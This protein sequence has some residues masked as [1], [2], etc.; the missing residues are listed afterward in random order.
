METGPVKLGQDEALALQIGRRL[1]AAR[2]ARR[3]RMTLAELGGGEIT[4]AMVSKIEHG[5][6]L[7]SLP[8]LLYLARRLGMPPGDLL[9]AD[10]VHDAIEQVLVARALLAAGQH[11]QA[12]HAAQQAAAS[13]QQTG[14]AAAHGYALAVLAA[15]LRATGRLDKAEQAL[16]HAT[17]L[18]ATRQ[19]AEL[20][21]ALLVE[22]ALLELEKGA[23][24][25]AQEHLQEA[26]RMA[27]A[28][29]VWPAGAAQALLLLGREA[30]RHRHLETARLLYRQAQALLQE[31]AR[32][33]ARAA[34]RLHRL[35]RA[36]GQSA[37][38]LSLDACRAEELFALVDAQRLAAEVE[39]RLGTLALEEGRQD[40][41]I[42]YLRH[43]LDGGSAAGMDVRST[44]AG[45]VPLRDEDAELTLAHLCRSRGDLVQFDELI[46]RAIAARLR[47]GQHDA[48]RRLLVERG[49]AWRDAGDYR[50]AAEA[51]RQAALTGPAQERLSSGL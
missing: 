40:E 34:A 22:R 24:T 10:G 41:A 16:D 25:R 14:A 51:Y 7:P 2:L 48:A 31:L 1:R 38:E 50:R 11:E 12:V 39:L 43:A 13:A 47:A 35:Q 5:Q 23:S 42:R 27:R 45:A 17:T 26:V 21:V 44:L 18:A 3:P 15:A 8:T 30:E 6:V 49:D 9:G 4:A 37:H 33:A 20:T 29:G 32:P 28:E 36:R 46:E 19:D